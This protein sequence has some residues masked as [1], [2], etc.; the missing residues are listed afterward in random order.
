MCNLTYTVDLKNYLKKLFFKNRFKKNPLYNKI[1]NFANFVCQL[2]S[3][4]KEFFLK[5]PIKLLLP[6]K[7]VTPRRSP[8]ISLSK[9]LYVTLI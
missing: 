7:T 3:T 2:R 1:N 6:V 8:N 9:N 5:C 4:T